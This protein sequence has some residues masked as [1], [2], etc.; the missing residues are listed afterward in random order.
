[1]ENEDEVSYR[2]GALE[3]LV[4]EKMELSR[5]LNIVNSL[6]ENHAEVLSNHG[7]DVEEFVNSIIEKQKQKAQQAQ[8]RRDSGG[9]RREQRSG[10]G[11]QRDQRQDQHSR[12]SGQRD[13]SPG[14]RRGGDEEDLS[15]DLLE[16]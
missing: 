8:E 4:N 11:G 10:K 5:L 6:I 7:V 12:N 9:G 14:K 15:G 1:M 2:K 16:P 3:A 13:F